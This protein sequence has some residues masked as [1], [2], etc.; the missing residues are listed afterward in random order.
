M[1]LALR[2]ID[3]LQWD[4][5]YARLPQAFYRKLNPTP[6]PDPYLISVSPSAAALLDLDP[7]TLHG[8]RMRDILAGNALPAGAEP[9]AMN[10]C[11]HQFGVFVPQLGDGRAL[12]LGETLNSRGEQIGRAHV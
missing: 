8:E 12:V 6:L 9:L 4:N 1:Q 5:R 3:T 7:A 10:Y 11:G 2:S